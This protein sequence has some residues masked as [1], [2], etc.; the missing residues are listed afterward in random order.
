MCHHA[1]ENLMSHIKKVILKNFR[2]FE[3]LN[4]EFNEGVNLILGKNGE[5]KT[6]ILEAIS[7]CV[8][9]NSFRPGKYDTYIK[10]NE[11]VSQIKTFFFDGYLD[12][13]SQLNF[14]E[15]KKEI[16]Y[17]S[18]KTSLAHL[19]KKNHY[20]LF[21]PESLSVI[22]EGPEERRNLIDS[23]LVSFSKENV[24]IISN[25]KKAL[26]TRNKILR[27]HKKELTPIHET[28]RLLN[29]LDE[30]YL[31]YATSLTT[32][33]IKVINKITPFV[34]DAFQFITG[35]KNVDISVDYIMSSEVI[36]DLQ[37]SKIYN[38]Y[39]MKR[40]QRLSTE[41]AT[42]TSLVG[43]HKHDIQFLFNKK[44]SRYFC[45]QGQQRALILAFK[46]AQ[47]IYHHSV[48]A[49]YPILLLDDVMSELDETKRHNLLTFLKNIKAQI[50]ITTTEYDLQNQIE[51]S[52]LSV[53]KIVKGRVLT[54]D[55][56][57][58]HL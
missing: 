24:E 40:E 39:Q 18:K 46:M 49:K 9:G 37:P 20:I 12:E 21:S 53:Y 29:S 14:F 22:K 30:L 15:T 48:F 47:I 13:D 51:Q 2:N 55:S 31:K 19:Q 11:S 16:F 36:N 58:V 17:N 43:P 5:G 4:L 38:K 56:T 1:D 42:G 28:H 27:D 34:K 3:F 8:S 41:L 33:R 10:F 23:V 50:F 54:D 52:N 57:E 45:S 6:S 26:K 35:D 32:Q 44:D 25:F 7:L